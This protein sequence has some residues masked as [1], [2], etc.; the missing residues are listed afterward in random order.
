M[1]CKYAYG[2]VGDEIVWH[3]GPQALVVDLALGSSQ[4][5][6]PH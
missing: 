4:L 5:L 6:F 2:C 3:A 1:A